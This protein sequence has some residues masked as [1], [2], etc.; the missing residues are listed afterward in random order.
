MKVFVRHCHISEA[1]LHKSRPQGF[2]REVL[3]QK[4]LQTCPDLFV[5]LDSDKDHFTEK[6]TSN[7][8]RIVGGC[9]SKSFLALIKVVKDMGLEESWNLNTPIVFLEDDYAV[10]TSWA[11]HIKEGLLFG[12]FVTLYDHPDKYINPIPCKIFLGEQCHWRTTPSTTNSYA[13]KFRTF[14]E[15]YEMQSKFSE[16]VSVTLDHYKFLSLWNSGKT[17]VSSLPGHWSHEET[18]MQSRIAE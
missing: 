17:L 11:D 15:T 16:N 10:S 14:L 3:F 9:E 1:S 4:V 5:V 7:I 2:D 8:I 13:M 6:Y 18:R 12:D